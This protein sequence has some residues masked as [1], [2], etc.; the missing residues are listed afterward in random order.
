VSI[1]LHAGGQA[2]VEISVP[3]SAMRLWSP[4]DPFLYEA[5][6]TVAERAEAL[7]STAARFGMREFTISGGDFLLN[8]ER[9]LLRGGN[10]AF[11]RF[12]SDP[13]RATLPWD[14]AWAK[15]LLIDIPRAHHFNFFRNHLGQMYNRWYDLADEHGMLLQNEWPFWTTTGTREQIT[16][17]FSRWLEDNW[18]H[19]SIV[20]WDA[21]NES[22]DPVVEQEVIP[23]MKWL[24]PTRPWEPVDVHEQHPYIYSLGPVLVDRRFGFTDA[25]DSIEKSVRPSMVN[26]FLWWWLDA[27]GEPTRLTREV[28]ER[29]LG[30]VFTAQE[31]VARQSF[32]ASEL[33]E[34]FRRMDVDAIQPFVYLS[35]S[36]GPTGHWF[37]GPIADLQPKPVLR[38]LANAFAPFGLSVE[39]WDRHFIPRE[40]RLVPVHLFNDSAEERAGHLRWGVADA[41][42][43]WVNEEICEVK[44]APVSRVV[45]SVEF[46]FPGAAGEYAAMA[47]VHDEHGLVA[48]SRKIAH[49]LPAVG[50]DERI[51]AL[52]CAFLDLRGE[53]EGFL[54]THG[55]VAVALGAARTAMVGEGSA[56][57]G[58]DDAR[59][60]AL[61]GLVKR[62]GTLILLEPE[63]GL[64]RS[65]SF[66]VLRDLCLE[67]SPRADVD[68]GG[69]DSYVFPT[70]PDHPLWEGLRPEHLRMFNGGY[71]GE[72]VSEH[73][74]A[75]PGLWTV[76]AR[77]GLKLA[78]PVVMEIPFG[79]GRVLVSRL[80]VRGRLE[81]TGGSDLFA[82]R[83]DP[84]AQQFLMNLVRYA[85]R[86]ALGG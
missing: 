59:I 81:G 84:V 73:D 43:T 68:R 22:T 25:L 71:G 85:T 55:V 34:L 30:P 58:F 77:C 7:D 29:W 60:E 63:Y 28:L 14:L 45:H 61:T 31:V 44:I 2:T 78:V 15:R 12:L 57:A 5:V 52:E 54:R 3:V 51:A 42:G 83:P 13:E 65:R 24:D 16:R 41:T 8:G 11:H 21:L 75:S 72:A 39:L 1:A 66:R 67:V 10:I 79:N 20:L 32:L 47:E 56:G 48:T 49:V 69:Y 37:S 46:R 40:R 64:N 6:V 9:I 36:A 62:G 80:Q 23:A 53:T 76:H 74:I 35:N 18:N 33:V 38:A 4:A 26:E 50:S 82:R 27:H 17:E 86:S 19:P 70:E